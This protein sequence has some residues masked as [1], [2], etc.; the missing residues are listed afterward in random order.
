MIAF[1]TT[2]TKRELR[3]FGLLFFP[4]FLAMVAW[5]AYR[6]TDS[7]MVAKVV[8]PLALISIVL[9]LVRPSAVTPFW[10]ITLTFPIGFVVSHVLIT[11]AF[12][13]ILT[14]AGFLLRLFKGDLLHRAADPQA[15]S[16]WVKR[17]EHP[18]K[19]R[20]FRQF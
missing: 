15:E 14:P 20:Y 19:E 13:G 12:Y 2:P 4:A 9:G 11:V 10:L 16:Y 3:Q 5:I 17:P 8:A 6:S 18:G 1:N 7:W